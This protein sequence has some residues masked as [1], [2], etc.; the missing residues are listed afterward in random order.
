MQI[1]DELPICELKRIQGR[2][3][4]LTSQIIS[5][6]YR[7]QTTC[8]YSLG[9][10]KMSINHRIFIDSI[11]SFECRNFVVVLQMSCRWT[12]LTSCAN[13]LYT[14]PEG[15]MLLYRSIDNI[16]IPRLRCMTDFYHGVLFCSVFYTIERLILNVIKSDI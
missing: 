3:H 8:T 14:Y 7:L 5:N 12:E 6:K 13:G 16:Y 11:S 9:G 10:E 15:N 4:L 2:N 1:V